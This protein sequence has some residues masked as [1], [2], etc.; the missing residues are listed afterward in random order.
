M[1]KEGVMIMAN[2]TQLSTAEQRYHQKVELVIP[3]T[4]DAFR[5]QRFTRG[6]RE[7]IGARTLT[8]TG[9]WKGTVIT[10]GL[11]K[12]V[13]VESIIDILMKLPEV[14]KAEEKQI[15]SKDIS[16]QRIEVIL[17]IGPIV[18]DHKIGL[19]PYDWAD[20]VGSV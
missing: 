19:H 10:L 12:P 16:R 4:D 1:K 5:L 14:E 7:T 13:P 8:M 6:V 11:P 17:G 18:D 3:S 2:M 15:K 9:S 20:V